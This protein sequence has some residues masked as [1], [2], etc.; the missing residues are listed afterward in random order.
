MTAYREPD[1][2]IDFCGEPMAYWLPPLPR[3]E[4]DEWTETD[5]TEEDER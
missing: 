4:P 2:Y 5:D 1:G 3:E